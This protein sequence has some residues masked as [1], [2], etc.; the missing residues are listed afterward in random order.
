MKNEIKNLMKIGLS[1]DLAILTAGVKCGNEDAVNEVL[2]EKNS[3][4]EELRDAIKFLVPFAPLALADEPAR[5]IVPETVENL[6]AVVDS[7]TNEVKP[8]VD[9]T[10]N[11]PGVEVFVEEIDHALEE[12]TDDLSIEIPEAP[13]E[14]EPAPVTIGK[15]PRTKWGPYKQ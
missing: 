11:M 3:E 1:E 8:F 14:V 7:I 2:Y 12:L 15:P 5:C 13:L 6:F 9:A 10:I 4:Q